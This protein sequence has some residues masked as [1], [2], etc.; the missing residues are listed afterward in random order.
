MEKIARTG[1]QDPR[2]SYREKYP[3]NV[4]K[5][6]P[7]AA[8]PIT[9]RN[10]FHGICGVFDKTV[11]TTRKNEIREYFLTEHVFLVST[12]KAALYLILSG[13]KALNKRKKV[14]IPAY[15]C[16][17]VPSA[18]LKA[19]LVVVP[20]DL[21]PE[22]LDFDFEEMKSL[23]DEE[24]LCV[25]PTHLFGIPSDI[26][27]I[28]QICRDKGAYVVEDAAQ[29]MG[30]VHNGKPLG[31]LGD[32]A[33]YSL[34]RGK[35][36]AC[37]SGGII[38]TP[39]GEIA[40]KIREEIHKLE[41]EPFFDYMKSLVDIFLMKIFLNPR[42]YWFPEGLPF[43]KIGETKFYKDFPIYELN[44]FKAGI[45]YDWRVKLE[46]NNRVRSENG[47]YYVNTLNLKNKMPIYSKSF[48]YLRFPIYRNDPEEKEDLC[49]RYRHLGISPMYPDSVNNIPEIKGSFKNVRYECAERIAKTLMTLP[50]HILVNEEDKGRICEV[51]RITYDSVFHA[52][53][54]ISK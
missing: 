1:D 5:T 17:S 3:M 20:C 6:N 22:T 47:G 30:A 53:C 37:G 23:V 7:P 27:K 54:T 49:K 43:L 33:F 31:T 28:R 4:R 15:T 29:A 12:G 40:E 41:R 44:R 39:S 14:I 21:R 50:T 2:P 26:E 18:I 48:P 45:L 10:L 19:N 9:F 8:V 13:L 51:F 38:I 52:N 34:G 46:T 11:V 42:L 36:I 35:N 16:Y 24:T 32:V 25:I